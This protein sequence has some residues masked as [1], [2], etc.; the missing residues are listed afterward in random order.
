MS[1]SECRW[2][3]HRLIAA[4]RRWDADF[5]TVLT[6]LREGTLG[7]VLEFES[8]FDRWSPEASGTWQ[9]ENIPG[10][11]VTYDLGS[12]LIDQIVFAL[13]MPKKITGFTSRQREGTGKAPD[14]ACT[15]LL[16]YDGMFASVKCSALSAETKQLRFWVRGEK[17]SFKKVCDPMDG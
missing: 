2:Q 10:H 8:H 12:H 14:D 5:Q 9:L 4:D 11:G 7:R 13:G 1:L 6:L 3:W 15:I 16:H 17:G